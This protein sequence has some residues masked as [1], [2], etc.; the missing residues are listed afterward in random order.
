MKKRKII[1]IQKRCDGQVA[2]PGSES[3]EFH[4]A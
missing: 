2:L 3:N 4:V 1:W